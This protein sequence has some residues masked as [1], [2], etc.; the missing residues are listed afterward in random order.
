MRVCMYHRKILI[1]RIHE[2][3]KTYE[4]NK[5]YNILGD[6]LFTNW[7]LNNMQIESTHFF[8]QLVQS[9]RHIW[10]SNLLVTEIPEF[11]ALMEV[12]QV[13]ILIWINVFRYQRSLS[14][15]RSWSYTSPPRLTCDG[16]IA[17]FGINL[18][19]LCLTHQ[20]LCRKSARRIW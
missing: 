2:T 17:S 4:F 5:W 15:M 11:T 14:W 18:G 9:L 6:W 10:N 19:T 3:M 1:Y 13:L 8:L 12:S 20:I 7:W 16:A